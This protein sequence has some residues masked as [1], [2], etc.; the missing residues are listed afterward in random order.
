ML[1]VPDFQ[2]LM[3]LVGYLLLRWGR[4][5]DSL[6]GDPVPAELAR[7]RRIRNAICHRM[8]AAYADPNG[9]GVAYV[10]CRFLDG[11]TAQYSAS[12]LEEAIRELE[13]KAPRR[14]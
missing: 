14:R 9:D 5:E 13:V 4:L 1:K 10:T 7:V 3:A 2:G 8:V 6:Q 11:I 12:E